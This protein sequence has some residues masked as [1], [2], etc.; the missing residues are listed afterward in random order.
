MKETNAVR[1]SNISG[2]FDLDNP[3]DNQTQDE[4]KILLKSFNQKEIKIIV[5]LP[6]FIDTDLKLVTNWLEIG[7]DGIYCALKSQVNIFLKNHLVFY[8]FTSNINNF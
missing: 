1:L 3:K 8:Y 5:D 7:V 2:L 6:I 4:L